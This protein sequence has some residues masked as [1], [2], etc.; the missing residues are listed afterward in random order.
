[1]PAFKTLDQ[2]DAR[3]KRVVVRV[4]LNVPMADGAITDVKTDLIGLPAGSQTR[5]T[6]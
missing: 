6:D 2:L 4:D 1:M 3:N 5:A